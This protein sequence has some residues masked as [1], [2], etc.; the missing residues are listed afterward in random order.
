M[1]SDLVAQVKNDGAERL[2]GRKVARPRKRERERER[3][4]IR[5]DGG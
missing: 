4:K 3:E 5:C 2:I 1:K